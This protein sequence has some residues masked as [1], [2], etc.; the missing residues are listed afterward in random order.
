MQP[1]LT[2]EILAVP[3]AALLGNLLYAVQGGKKQIPGKQDPACNAVLMRIDAKAG[4]I[5]R[6]Q[7]SGTVGTGESCAVGLKKHLRGQIELIS[8][9]KHL[10]VVG[11][12]PPGSTDSGQLIQLLQRLWHFRLIS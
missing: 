3:I 7:V 5:D 1:E 4:F 10:P 11:T 6:P 12:S 8:Q 9:H 2:Q